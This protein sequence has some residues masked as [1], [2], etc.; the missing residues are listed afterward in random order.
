MAL[1]GGELV[2]TW[3]Q[4]SRVVERGEGVVVDFTYHHRHTDGI[5][6]VSES[7]LRFRSEAEVRA[8]LEAAGFVVDHIVGGWNGEPVGAG[9]G[10]LLVIARRE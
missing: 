5:E 9:D 10:E 4:L 2:E 3:A 6:L 1:T 7:T 8:S